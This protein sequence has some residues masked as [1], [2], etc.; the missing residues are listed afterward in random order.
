MWITQPFV[1]IPTVRNPQPPVDN[2][3]G[4]VN[5]LYAQLLIHKLSTTN[6]QGYPQSYPHDLA[7]RGGL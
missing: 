1:A 7:H 6:P 3:R 2:S 4:A 5:Y